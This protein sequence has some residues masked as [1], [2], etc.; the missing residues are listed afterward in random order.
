MEPLTFDKVKES[1]EFLKAKIGGG[2]MPSI[3]IILGSGLS[4]FVDGM[5][6]DHNLA[7]SDIP[8]FPRSTVEGH[9]G[10]LLIGS[11]KGVPIAVMQGRA[12]YYEGVDIRDTAIPIHTLHILGCKTLIVSNAAGGINAAF[13]PGDIMMITDHINMMG[14]NPLR[15]IGGI[16]PKN[17]F[18]DM[19][20]AYSKTLQQTVLDIAKQLEVPLKQ[21]V[22]IGM[23]GPSYET[24]AEIRA[25]RQ[26]GADAVGMSTV[27]EVI[28]ANYHKMQVLGF[29]CIANPSADLHIGGMSHAEVLKAM[30]IVKPN[31]VK[32]IS[33]VLERLGNVSPQTENK[34][35]TK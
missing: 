3:M 2:A 13:V 35:E 27:P 7:Y 32:L 12:H 25:F 20:N 15:G 21:G 26:W 8:H 28:V 5:K 19:T 23:A 17:T 24:K 14:V 31:L 22:F 4:S 18:P 6:V 29:S 11:W 1:V 10:H 34:T 33:S 16:N 9:T 30:E